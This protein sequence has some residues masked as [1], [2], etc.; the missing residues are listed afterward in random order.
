MLEQI[1]KTVQQ[2]RNTATPRRERAQGDYFRFENVKTVSATSA[3]RQNSRSSTK[4][5][6]FPPPSSSTNF[7]SSSTPYSDI[8]PS[9]SSSF[10]SSLPHHLLFHRLLPFSL[11][12]ICLFPPTPSFSSSFVN[13]FFSSSI[14]ID[15]IFFFSCHL[16]FHCLSPLSFLHFFLASSSS[17][18]FFFSS[19]IDVFFSSS[20]SFQFYSFSSSSSFFFSFFTIRFVQH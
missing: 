8:L 1:R 10:P 6:S 7:S 9:P 4:P 14:V 20:F 17:Y 5:Y 19:I 3:A 13:L 12:I 16:P 2:I 15:L 18:S 11:L